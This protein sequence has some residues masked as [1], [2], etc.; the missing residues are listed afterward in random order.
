MTDVGGYNLAAARPREDYHLGR[1]SR[2]S[3]LR[4]CKSFH[5]AAARGPQGRHLEC[6]QANL[7]RPTSA[8][9]GAAKAIISDVVKPIFCDRLEAI[10]S[11]LRGAAKA[12][13][14]ECRQVYLLCPIR[15]YN[16][17]AVRAHQGHHLGCRQAYRLGSCGGYNLGTA[18]VH[19]GHHLGRRLAYLR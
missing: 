5:L 2:L 4:S 17:G 12:I 8:L 11:V 1:L 13:I 14:S 9:R 16:L 10:I 7:L 3:S 6:R 18:R 19:Q 15:H